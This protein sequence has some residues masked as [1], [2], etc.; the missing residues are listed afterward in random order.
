VTCLNSRF[1]KRYGFERKTYFSC[2][3]RFDLLIVRRIVSNNGGNFCSYIAHACVFFL[4]IL[5]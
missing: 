5:Y 3:A 2:F 1:Q 4:C